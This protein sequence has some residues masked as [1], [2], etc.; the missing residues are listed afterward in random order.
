[1][2]T[3]TLLASFGFEAAPQFT[4]VAAA[5]AEV[6]RTTKIRS[7]AED[8]I[9]RCRTR[10]PASPTD[11]VIVTTVRGPTGGESGVAVDFTVVDP[12]GKAQDRNLTEK[13]GPNGSLLL[14]VGRDDLGSSF[15][16]SGSKGDRRTDT[17][18]AVLRARIT[19]FRLTLPASRPPRWL[20]AEREPAADLHLPRAGVHQDLGTHE[21]H[22]DPETD[23]LR[24]VRQR[25]NA[26]AAEDVA[27]GERRRP[28]Q[29][30]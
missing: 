20:P 4:F 25:V 12:E 1:M 26:R 5:D 8:L 21:R 30:K 18:T 16:V 13:T 19:A 6:K 3:D 7:T 24:Q 22:R 29:R 11:L 17:A 27:K 15:T 2:V 14:C 9:G 10:N 28:D 23:D